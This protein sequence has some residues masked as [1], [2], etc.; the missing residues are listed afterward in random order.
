MFAAQ[1]DDWKVWRSFTY[2]TRTKLKLYRSCVLAPLLYGSECS[3]LTEKH[4]PKLSTFHTKSLRHILLISWSNVI[5]IKDLLAERCETEVMA[6]ILMTWMRRRWRWIAHITRQEASIA[7]TTL[8]WTPEE[9]R[10]RGRPKITWRRMV[11][12]EITMSRLGRPGK[13]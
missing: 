9:K 6:T 5:S 2:S 7:K 8:Y 13:A 10:K 12:K 3:R 1:H 4:T 11:E